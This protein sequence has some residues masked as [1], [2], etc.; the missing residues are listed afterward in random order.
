MS[1]LDHQKTPQI[2]LEMASPNKLRKHQSEEK[3]LSRSMS[4]NKKTWSYSFSPNKKGLNEAPPDLSKVPSSSKLEVRN[5]DK[6]TK[7]HCGA[8][9]MGKWCKHENWKNCENPYI[10]GL[11][12]EL[13]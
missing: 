1:H 6:V 9:C 10:T 5:F 11:H 13:V 8:A 2:E 3:G 4:P 7:L 12:S